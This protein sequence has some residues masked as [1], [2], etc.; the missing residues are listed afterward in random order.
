M[1]EERTYKVID[2]D[3]SAHLVKGERF[4]YASRKDFEYVM[5]SAD[6]P[7]AYFIKPIGVVDVTAIAEAPEEPAKEEVKEVP[8]EATEAV[9]EAKAEAV[10]E[11]PA[12]A[13]K[14]EPKPKKKATRKTTKKT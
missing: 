10:T 9:A 8:E 13:P 5:I 14:E 3:G 1:A 12:E 2:R 11:P 7:V 6:A 4:E